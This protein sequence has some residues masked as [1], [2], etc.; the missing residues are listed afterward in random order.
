MEAGQREGTTASVS[1][2]FPFREAV[3]CTGETP[4]QLGIYVHL[5][6]SLQSLTLSHP[7]SRLSLLQDMLG[8]L[9]KETRERILPPMLFAAFFF[10]FFYCAFA[11]SI[12]L[13]LYGMPP[14]HNFTN[15]PPLLGILVGDG[16]DV[17]SKRRKGTEWRG[18]GIIGEREEGIE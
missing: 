5:S 18:R 13:G 6:V 10:L 11:L 15:N 4:K 3:S 14:T 16:F 7:L 2:P 8:K 12:H 1:P 17:G 9:K